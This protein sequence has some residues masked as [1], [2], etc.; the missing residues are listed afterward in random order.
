FPVLS[1]VISTDT[2][3]TIT[4]SLSAAPDTTYTLEFYSNANPDPSGYGEGQSL[5]MSSPV[6]TDDSGLASFA[7]PTPSVLVPG[8]S[9]T[10]TATD[11]VGNTSE[12]S[13]DVN[14]AAETMTDVQSSNPTSVFGE[15]LTFTATVSTPVLGLPAPTGSVQILVDGV[16]FG[17]V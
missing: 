6:T 14:V 13:G 9:I 7:L 15:Q 8:Q 12:F 16:D 2:T 17:S 5:I 3:T 1:S 11:P 10:A 4:G